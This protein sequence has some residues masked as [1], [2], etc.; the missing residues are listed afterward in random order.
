MNKPT[1]FFDANYMG[2]DVVIENFSVRGYDRKHFTLSEICGL[3]NRY[4]ARSVAIISQGDTIEI[5]PFEV[6]HNM[7]LSK[8]PS[9]ALPQME[10]MF[11]LED[12]SQFTKENGPRLIIGGGNTPFYR[13][14]YEPNAYVV[15]DHISKSITVRALKN[16]P[17]GHEITI[18]RYG[19]F[20]VLKNNMQIQKFYQDRQK[21]VEQ[22][23][24]NAEGFR[25][26]AA[27]EIKNIEAIEV[28]TEVKVENTE[29]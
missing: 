23:N 11:V 29:Q 9:E 6:L 28:Q 4:S 21:Q 27:N 24:V 19:S 20:Q 14:S 2:Q 26:M 15:F 18:Y 22:N 13:H 12:H 3:N 7:K 10:Y 16:I 17:V 5:A 1:Y 8:D 25:S